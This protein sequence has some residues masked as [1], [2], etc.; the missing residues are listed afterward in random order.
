MLTNPFAHHIDANVRVDALVKLIP[1]ETLIKLAE[2]DRELFAETDIDKRSILKT[3]MRLNAGKGAWS[4]I[5]VDQLLGVR[6]LKYG[7]HD[8]LA[9]A[10]SRVAILKEDV[11]W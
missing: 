7:V 4:H 11:P 1:A 9:L 6:P 2:I 10:A 8:I 5:L 3:E